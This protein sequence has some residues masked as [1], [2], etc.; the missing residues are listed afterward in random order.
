MFLVNRFALFP[1]TSAA[2][3]PGTDWPFGSAFPAG[4][5]LA[6]PEEEGVDRD[7]G[8][9]QD[10]DAGKEFRHPQGG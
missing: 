7:A 9:G 8:H 5:F 4:Q 1:G 3:C 6:Q 2:E 10:Q